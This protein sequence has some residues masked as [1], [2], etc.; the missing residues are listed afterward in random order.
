VCVCV[1]STSP[2]EAEWLRA[3]CETAVY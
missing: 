2:G 3:K 1:H